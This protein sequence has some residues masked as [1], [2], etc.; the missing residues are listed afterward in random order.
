MSVEMM[1]IFG[2]CPEVLIGD[3][4]VQIYVE[5]S[6]GESL[7]KFTLDIGMAAIKMFACLNFLFQSYLLLTTC[8]RFRP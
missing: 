2:D 8:A 1:K 4:A 3:S 6:S 7:I 5:R